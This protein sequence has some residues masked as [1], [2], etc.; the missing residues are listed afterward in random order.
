MKNIKDITLS[1]FAIIGFISI[2]TAFNTQP[3][4]QTH[5]TPESHVWEIYGNNGGQYT[6]TYAY[7]YNKVTGE[8]RKLSTRSLSFEKNGTINDFRGDKYVLMAEAK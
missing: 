5:G 8:V 6:S 4:Q 7:M 3:E 2:I 1:I